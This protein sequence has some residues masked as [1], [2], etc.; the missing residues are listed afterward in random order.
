[1]TREELKKL[2]N[3]LDDK[4]R[5]ELSLKGYFVRSLDETKVF[6]PRGCELR[7]KSKKKRGDI[8][9]CSKSSCSRCPTPCCTFTEKRKWKEAAFSTSCVI[10]GPIENLLNDLKLLK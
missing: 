1:M 6:C 10:K 4:K 9:Y 7:K 2:I 8:R 5:K 3:P